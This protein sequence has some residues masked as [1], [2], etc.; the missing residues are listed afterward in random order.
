MPAHRKDINMLT[1]VG[2]VAHD[3]QR[4]TD[5]VP[6]AP[7]DEL[8]AECPR[9][10]LLTFEE[11]WADII[12]LAPVGVLR[13]RDTI[14]VQ[15]A[16]RLHMLT[17]NLLVL[18]RLENGSLPFLDNSTHKQLMAVLS[19]LGLSPTDARNVAAPAKKTAAETFD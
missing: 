16:A 14:L 2:S 15:E 1:L 9:E 7:S 4:F 19:K 10:R 6:D 12:E 8:R 11:A 5:R 18:S 3:A 17:N 13:K